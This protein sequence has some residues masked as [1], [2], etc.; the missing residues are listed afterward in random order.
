[1]IESY[2]K[3]YT[4]ERQELARK[5]QQEYD[6]MQREGGKASDYERELRE[7]YK[8]LVE[9]DMILQKKREAERI[10]F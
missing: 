10:I 2:M 7:E 6:R 8:L 3:P 1:M 9:F 5:M 4:K